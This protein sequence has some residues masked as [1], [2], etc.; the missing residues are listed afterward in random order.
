MQYAYHAINTDLPR[1]R[2]GT[3]DGST[4]HSAGNSARLDKGSARVLFA[5]AKRTVLNARAYYAHSEIVGNRWFKSLLGEVARWRNVT[6]FPRAVSAR[7]SSD[8]ASP[9][10]EACLTSEDNMHIHLDRHPASTRCALVLI[11]FAAVLLPGLAIAQQD[12]PAAP[13]PDTLIFTNG[14]QLT[15]KLLRATGGTITFHSD[16]AGDLDIPVAKIR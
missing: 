1:K 12:A 7:E 2:S 8:R 13:A 6:P 9:L 5:C 16:M 14:D 11:A 3:G 15:G 4:R 10:T